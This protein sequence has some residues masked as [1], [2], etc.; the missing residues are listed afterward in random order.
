MFNVINIDHIAG[1]KSNLNIAKTPERSS[2]RAAQFPKDSPSIS[3]RKKIQNVEY[4]RR[5][6]GKN[7]GT[8]SQ[9]PT[10]QGLGSE[11]G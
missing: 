3:R 5:K 2:V 11:Q 10:W 7:D 8:G 1:I 6:H 4:Y 9:S